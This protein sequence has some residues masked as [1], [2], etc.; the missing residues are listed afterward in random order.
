MCYVLLNFHKM[1]LALYVLTVFYSLSNNECF[2]QVITVGELQSKMGLN[3]FV[4][5]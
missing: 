3:P 5:Q 1:Y 4:W 2:A